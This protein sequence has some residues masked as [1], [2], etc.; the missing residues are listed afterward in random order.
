MLE[1]LNKGCKGG[2][3]SSVWKQT[4]PDG[5][6]ASSSYKKYNAIATGTCS[7]SVPKEANS[8]VEKYLQIPVG[9]EDALKCHL[10]KYGPIAI[11]LD[12]SGKLMYYKSGIVTSAGI[13]C[14]LSSRINH[15]SLLVGYG[16]NWSMQKTFQETKFFFV[17]SGTENNKAG[18]PI[19][20]WLIKNSYGSSWGEK[21]YLRLAMNQGNL[22]K[23]ASYAQFP[24]LKNIGSLPTAGPVT[25]KYSC[26]LNKLLEYRKLR[27]HSSKSSWK[28]FFPNSCRNNCMLTFDFH[29]LQDCSMFLNMPSTNIHFPTIA[30]PDKTICANIIHFL[31]QNSTSIV[32]SACIVQQT[33]NYA[34]SAAFCKSHG[35]SL[36]IND[37]ATPQKTFLDAVGGFMG[38]AT[39][40][41]VSLFIGGKISTLNCPGINNARKSFQYINLPCLQKTYSICQF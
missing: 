8:V 3:F 36:F 29:F 18:Q 26:L 24:I 4:K 22:C 10:V 5:V 37:P 21:G 15:A 6:A 7:N 28:V 39:K 9:D 2:P 40:Q 38:T 30:G 13:D 11:G 17:M 1:C 25:R 20:Y 35:M 12:F 34:D 32:N 23:V 33:R 19:D 14:S 41:T 31:L 16:K 27:R